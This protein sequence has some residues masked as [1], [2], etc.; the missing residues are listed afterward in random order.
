MVAWRSASGVRRGKGSQST[1]PDAWSYPPSPTYFFSTTTKL[2]GG[3]VSGLQPMPR[4]STERPH[5][6]P[7]IPSPRCTP[8]ATH[9][10]RGSG[11]LEIMLCASGG[12]VFGWLGRCLQGTAKP[13]TEND[14]KCSP[15]LRGSGRGWKQ[16]GQFPLHALAGGLPPPTSVVTDVG[17]AGWGVMGSIGSPSN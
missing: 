6:P 14:P 3:V 11:V 5:F 4:C 1:R 10:R 12:V 9:S 2:L 17:G 15:P 16:G 7:P 13:D 8:T